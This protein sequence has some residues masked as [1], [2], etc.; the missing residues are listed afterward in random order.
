MKWLGCTKIMITKNDN[1]EH[2]SNIETTGIVLVHCNIV[3]NGYQ[4]DSRALSTFIL[5]KSFG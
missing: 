5:N 2:A 4:Q 3:D 1:G